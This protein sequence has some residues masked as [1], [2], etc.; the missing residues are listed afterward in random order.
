MNLTE[1]KEELT[2]DLTENILPYWTER[3][4]DPAGGYFGRRDGYD[5]L[6]ADAERGAILNARILWTFSAAYR[7][8]GHEEYLHAADRAL[9]YITEHFIDRDFGGVYW[10]VNADGSPLDTKKQFYAIAFTIYGLSEYSRATGDAAARDL[11]MSLFGDI[12]GHSRDLAK[13]GYI[14]AAMRD[15]SLIADM[16]LSDKDENASKTMNTHLHILEAYTALLRVSDDPAVREA[17]RN[18]IEIFLD[19]IEDPETHHLGLFFNDDWHRLD[20][21]ESYGHDIEASWLLLEAAKVQDDPALTGRVMEHTRRIALAALDGRE[22]DGSMV[23]ELHRGDAAAD[24]NSDSGEWL[25]TEKHWWVQ[26]ENV[27]GQLYLWKFHGMKDML[28]RAM[29]SWAYI[30]ENLIDRTDGEWYWSRLPDGSVNRRDDKAGFW[31]CPYH[32]SRMHLEAL[33]L[34]DETE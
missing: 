18:L 7:L 21:N 16:R 12:E 10:S 30:R 29:Q 32:N 15:W 20:A 34:L 1:F 26:A 3:M 14:E 24:A 11:A 33:A 8:T 22:A 2:R 23:Y 9:E 17:H 31:K 13:G 28:D 25:D 6:H 4:S 19:R 27:V 5:R